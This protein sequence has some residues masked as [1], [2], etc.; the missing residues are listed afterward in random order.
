MINI[1]P[2]SFFRLVVVI[3]FL[4]KV[5]SIFLFENTQIKAILNFRR[6]DIPSHYVSQYPE[7]GP[8]VQNHSKRHI[9]PFKSI[10]RPVYSN[11]CWKNI[12]W[13]K[14]FTKTIRIMAMSRTGNKVITF[15]KVWFLAFISSVFYGSPLITRVETNNDRF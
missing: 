5:I 14:R 7:F 15:I 10:Q 9:F 6:I 3:I 1:L 11:F 2:V 4:L 12:L 8:K 13:K